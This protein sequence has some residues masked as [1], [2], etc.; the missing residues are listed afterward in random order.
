MGQARPNVLFE[1]G[2]ALASHPDET[3]LVQVGHVKQFSDVTGGHF[4]KM[5]NSVAKRQELALKLKTAGCPVNMEGTDWHDA[6]DL[7]P[8][9][10]TR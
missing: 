10:K 9:L 5:D 7:R 2:M 3:I 8:L 4:V 1:A 6:G